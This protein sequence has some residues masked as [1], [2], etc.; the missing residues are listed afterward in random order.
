M[1]DTL[2]PL[3]IQPF[4]VALI[5]FWSMHFLFFPHYFSSLHDL[6]DFQDPSVSGLV[7]D[8]SSAFQTDPLEDMEDILEQSKQSMKIKDVKTWWNERVRLD[9]R[10][11]VNYWEDLLSI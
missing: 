5:L 11:Q 7:R 4:K 3:T 6:C 2:L 8:L 1:K 10:L 9:K